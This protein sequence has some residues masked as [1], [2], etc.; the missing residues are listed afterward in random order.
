MIRL[1]YSTLFAFLIILI[2]VLLLYYTWKLFITNDRTNNAAATISGRQHQKSDGNLMVAT[3]ERI[4]TKD[5]IQYMNK[6]IKKILT[7]VFR[8][9]YHFDNDLQAS[10]DSILLL[11]PNIQI[12]VVYDEEPYPP[13]EYMS[14]YSTKS[15]IKIINMG[16]DI[17]KSMKLPILQVKTKYVLLMPDSVRLGGRSIIQK[18]IRE[19]SQTVQTSVSSSNNNNNNKLENSG[20]A[21]E[22]HTKQDNAI[23]PSIGKEQSSKS[24]LGIPFA[25]SNIRGVANCCKIKLDFANW[26][27]EYK[28]KNGSDD[29]DMVKIIFELIF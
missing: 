28:I 22:K 19:L 24:L 1:K 10:I 5:K 23:V 4:K 16:F 7:I 29:C 8:D 11:I 9:F 26:M 17:K 6:H 20:A 25:S 3:T 14:N 13:M 12:M 15:N 2:H 27:L 18:M 21:G